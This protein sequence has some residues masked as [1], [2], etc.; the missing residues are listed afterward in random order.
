MERRS[1]ILVCQEPSSQTLQNMYD[2]WL[3]VKPHE[4]FNLLPQMEPHVLSLVHDDREAERETNIAGVDTQCDAFNFGEVYQ[5]S[6]CPFHFVS[7]ENPH[8]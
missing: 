8:R 3:S 4:S 2:D 5:R 6:T 7:L 1:I